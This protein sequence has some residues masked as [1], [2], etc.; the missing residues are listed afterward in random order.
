MVGEKG[1]V[2]AEGVAIDVLDEATRE[3]VV[4]VD[5]GLAHGSGL[6]GGGGGFEATA[7][8]VEDHVDF[9]HAEGRFARFQLADKAE[10]DTCAVGQLPLGQVMGFS[11]LADEL[12]NGHV[13]P[14]RC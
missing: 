2:V 10:S 5:V 3:A 11:V 13:I 6:P 4:Q 14:Y 1:G 12:G 7:E 8:E 9:V